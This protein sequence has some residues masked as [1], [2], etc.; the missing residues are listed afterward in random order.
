VCLVIITHTIVSLT[1]LGRGGL[2]CVWEIFF[3]LGRRFSVCVLGLVFWAEVV[4]GFVFVFFACCSMLFG[5]MFHV[6]WRD[7]CP[8]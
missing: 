4:S 8:C 5:V 6:G 2:V 7:V 3:V 1:C